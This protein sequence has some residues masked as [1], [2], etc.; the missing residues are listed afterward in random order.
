VVGNI[1]AI[2]LIRQT[3]LQPHNIAFLLQIVKLLFDHQT[4]F[5]NAILHLQT[6]LSSISWTLW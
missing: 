5:R 3:K 2:Y 6:P 4:V 1:L